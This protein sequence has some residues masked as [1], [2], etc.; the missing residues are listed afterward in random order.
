M[1]NINTRVHKS[2]DLERFIAAQDPV[3]E[4]VFAELALGCK[5]T[6]WMWFVFPQLRCLGRSHFAVYFGIENLSEARTYLAHTALGS[7]LNKCVEIL[8]VLENRTALQIFGKVDTKKLQSC[9]TLFEIAEGQNSSLFT[10]VLDKYYAGERDSG[11]IENIQTNK[12]N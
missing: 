5:T 3:M 6:H 10:Q 4:Q 8:L 9:L 1:K 12:A 7:R 2:Y 11:T